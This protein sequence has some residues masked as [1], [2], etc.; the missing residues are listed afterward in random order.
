[1]TTTAAI[2]KVAGRERVL[3][4]DVYDTL[5]FE[6]LAFGG[7]GAGWFADLGG[8]NVEDHQGSLP[9]LDEEG[10]APYCVYGMASGSGE[11]HN[12]LVEAEIFVT[13]NDSAVARI[14]ARLGRRSQARVP[15]DLWCEELNVVRASCSG[16]VVEDTEA[17]T[18]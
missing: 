6:A 12:A 13:D 10:A 11:M 17:P 18:K 15:F 5:E 14:N 9:W 1:M 7:I 2:P 4:A 3:P 16:I 8:V